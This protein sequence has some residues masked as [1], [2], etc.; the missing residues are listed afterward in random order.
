M[1]GRFTNVNWSVE[2][3]MEKKDHIVSKGDLLVELQKT[4]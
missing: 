1:S 2:E 3:L 4:E